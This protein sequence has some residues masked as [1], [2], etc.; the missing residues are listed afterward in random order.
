MYRNWLLML[1]VALGTTH[2]A[3]AQ[4]DKSKFRFGDVKP[5]DFAVKV[6]PIDSSADAVYHFDVGSSEYE[7]NNK[8]YLSVIFRTKARIH[9]LNKKSFEDLSTV[10]ILLANQADNLD[11]LDNLDAATYNLENGKVVVT[12]VDKASIFKEKEDG[13]IVMK[14]TFPNIKEGSIIEYD[15]KVSSP[16]P[17]YLNNWTFQDSYPKLWSEYTVAVPQYYD[18]I[19]FKQGYL[20]YAVDTA[21]TYRDNFLI[22]DNGDAGSSGA[23]GSVTATVFKHKWAIQNVPSIKPEAFTTTINNYRSKISFQFSALRRADGSIKPYLSDWGSMVDELMKRESFGLD[24]THDLDWLNDDVKAANALNGKALDNAKNIFAHVQ[25]NYIVTDDYGYSLSQPLRK[26]AQTK[27]GNAADINMLLVAMLK[28]VGFEAYPVLLSTRS[29]GKTYDL[30]P[31]MNKFNYTVAQV[32][33]S[34]QTYLLD[35][36]DK[37]LGF[38]HLSDDC[39]NGNARL[40]A[41]LPALI[42]LSPDSLKETS[43]TFVAMQNEGDNTMT[44][45]Y[46]SQLGEMQS[47]EVRRAL[48]K[49]S[50]ED[51]FKEVLKG[52]SESIAVSNTQ[53]DSLKQPADPVTVKFDLSAKF[54]EDIIYFNP[55]LVDAERENPFT[56]AERFYPVEMPYASDRTYL[57]NMEVPKGYKVDELPKSA[58]INF[59]EDEG[60][61]E[62]IIAESG[63]RV[64]LRCRLRFNKATFEP[65]DY[66]TLREFYSF[67]V[68]KE[69]EQIVFKK[70]Q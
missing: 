53:I 13:Y 59:N 54:D 23:A 68:A 60:S 34:G 22:R 11:R 52:N 69:G 18:F 43:L 66:E 4:K 9:L 46:S 64:Q 65:E 39:Y 37:N 62:Y 47:L 17:G 20:P 8:G 35:A 6:Y 14:F 63:G 55:M 48:N 19:T 27:K 21:E 36:A 51:F 12:K 61:F 45:H 49:A 40:V 38:G 26:T 28:N 30:Y 10:K 7:G 1:V 56:A 5:E 41:P 15:Y 67:V 57:L 33:I 42:N 29:H 3:T 16:D 24:L 70:I 50:K 32:S 58:R 44:G 25:S 31:I 2:T